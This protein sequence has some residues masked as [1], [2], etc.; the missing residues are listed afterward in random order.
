MTSRPP[1]R[2]DVH[3]RFLRVVARALER[4]EI[5]EREH[6]ARLRTSGYRPGMFREW[7]GRPSGPRTCQAGGG[8]QNDDGRG[9][10]LQSTPR[11]GI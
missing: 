3:E 5:E 11:R 4:A 2:A 10:R 6:L 1:I 7:R 8:M 9:E